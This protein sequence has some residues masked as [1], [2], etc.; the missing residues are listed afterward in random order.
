MI[1]KLR[2]ESIGDIVTKLGKDII[3]GWLSFASWWG[4]CPSLVQTAENCLFSTAPILAINLAVDAA[5]EVEDGMQREVLPAI[6]SEKIASFH[7]K[8][9][10]TRSVDRFHRRNKHTA[11]KATPKYHTY[12]QSS[13]PTN[14]ILTNLSQRSADIHQELYLRRNSNYWGLTALRSWLVYELTWLHGNACLAGVKLNINF[15]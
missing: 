15:R 8:I 1:S 12:A 13:Q 11:I 9:T 3:V 4:S 6:H 5:F 14:T 7:V 10:I 2:A